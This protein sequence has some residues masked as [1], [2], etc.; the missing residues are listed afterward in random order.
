[1]NLEQMRYIVEA[2]K[3]GSFTQVAKNLNITLPAIS[4]SISLLESELGLSLFTRSRGVGATPT[5]EGIA[6]ITKANEILIKVDEILEEAQSYTN[7]LSGHLRIATI[8][9]PMHLLVD[10]VSSFKKDFPKIK[11]EIIEKGTKEILEDIH[12][13]H[14]DIGFIVLSEEIAQKEKECYFDRVLEG[15]LVVGVNKNSPLSLNKTILPHQLS[16][17]TLVLYDDEFIRTFVY[18][19]IAQYGDV[20]VL[21]VTNNTRAIQNAVKQGIAVTIGLDYS[22]ADKQTELAQDL[23]TIDLELPFASPVYYGL[24]RRKDKASSNILNRFIHRI[25]VGL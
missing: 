12:A 9:G 6:I 22:F 23:I 1:M 18:E 7:A 15:K 14:V 2:A 17:H 13:N 16:G 25:H 3:T 21:F 5:P 20:N 11:I 4:Q 24:V 10:T 19:L 8:P